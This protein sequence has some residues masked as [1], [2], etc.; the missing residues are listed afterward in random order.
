MAKY[1]G[2]LVAVILSISALS[3]CDTPPPASDNGNTKQQLQTTDSEQ[4]NVGSESS[5]NDA[6]NSAEPT[7]AQNESE[8]SAFDDD[9]A[10]PEDPSV[11]KDIDSINELIEQ[12]YYDDAQMTLNA[13]KTR[14]LTAAQKEETDK[15]QKIID[16]NK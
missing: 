12:G 15:L 8:D 9:S 2:L 3:A 10:V 14:K 1:F 6:E 13:L 7:D 11:Q 16:K 4:N 5:D